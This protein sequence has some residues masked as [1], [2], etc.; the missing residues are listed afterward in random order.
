MKKNQTLFPQIRGKFKEDEEIIE[1][2]DDF[3]TKEELNLNLDFISPFN[4]EKN[5]AVVNNINSKETSKIQRKKNSKISKSLINNGISKL[6]RNTKGSI[7]LSKAKSNLTI[8]DKFQKIKSPIKNIILNDSNSNIN[9]NSFFKSKNQFLQKFQKIYIIHIGII[10][11]LPK[12][13]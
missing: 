13:L 7:H 3:G 5:K 9:I 11:L 6:I 4:D 8:K 1:N 12:I 2:I 10:Y